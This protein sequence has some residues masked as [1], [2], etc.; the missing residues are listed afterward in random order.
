MN[1][2][3]SADDDL[4]RKAR[5]YSRRHG[6]S[7]NELIRQYL[8]EIVGTQTREETAQDFAEIAESMAGDSGGV[9]WSGREELYAGRMATLTGETRTL[10]RGNDVSD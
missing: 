3:L 1:I 9:G 5:E 8:E 2:T 4:V 7:L 10:P 6:T